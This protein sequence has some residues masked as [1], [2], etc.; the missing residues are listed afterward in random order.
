MKL[1]TLGANKTI[2]TMDNGDEFF[3]SYNTCVAGYDVGAGYWKVDK[4]YSVTTSKHVNSYLNGN[5]PELVETVDVDI[6]LSCF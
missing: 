5:T 4:I 1:N 3:F 6:A 2:I